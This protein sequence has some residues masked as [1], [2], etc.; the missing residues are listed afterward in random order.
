MT[1]ASTGISSRIGSNA[2]KRGGLGLVVPHVHRLRDLD[3]QVAEL[4]GIEPV[5][6]GCPGSR[7]RSPA[8]WRAA[9]CSRGEEEY[10]RLPSRPRSPTSISLSSLTAAARFVCRGRRPARHL[11]KLVIQQVLGLV[12]HL[13]VSNDRR[14]R[15]DRRDCDPQ[16]HQQPPAQ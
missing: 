7:P 15:A 6:L 8:R 9:G 10:C 1:M 2:A 13:Q 11:L 5:R 4:R 14:Q 3:M 16:R 12:A